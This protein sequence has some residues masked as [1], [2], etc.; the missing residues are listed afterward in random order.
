MQNTH[1]IIQTIIN[2]ALVH[3]L[4]C[5][6]Q[7]MLR[8]AYIATRPPMQFIFP[9]SNTAAFPMYASEPTVVAV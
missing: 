3:E 2:G 8:H 4:T 5:S 6:L 1:R 7:Y 9:R